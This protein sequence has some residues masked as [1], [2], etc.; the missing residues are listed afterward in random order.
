MR[1][2]FRDKYLTDTYYKN[3]CTYIKK[4]TKEN[5]KRAEETLPQ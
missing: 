3:I 4:S 2:I 5:K 1:K